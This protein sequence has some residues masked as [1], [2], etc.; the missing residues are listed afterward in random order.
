MRIVKM[1]KL[2]QTA[3]NSRS[4]PL[5]M[6][7]FWQGAVQ[8]QFLSLLSNIDEDGLSRMN[9]ALPYAALVQVS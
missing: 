3:M 7:L 1:V 8:K 9:S 2:S 4:D 5:Q 6:S